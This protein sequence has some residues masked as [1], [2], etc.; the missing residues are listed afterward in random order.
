MPKKKPS[1]KL[2]TVLTEEHEAAQGAALLAEAMIS[3]RAPP[4]RTVTAHESL[5]LEEQKE[6]ELSLLDAAEEGNV[7][8]VT[9]LLADGVPIEA[10]DW[11][12]TAL[13]LACEKGH[14][15]LAQ[16]LLDR[17]ARVTATSSFGNSCLVYAARE[18][19]VKIVQSLLNHKAD[20]SKAK[21]NGESPI[22]LAAAGG[23]VAIVGRL[24]A[25]DADVNAASASGES[26][27]TRAAEEG[28]AHVVRA[29]L[30]HGAD[31]GAQTRSGETA[32]SLA[33][34]AGHGDVV[35]LLVGSSKPEDTLAEVTT[36]SMNGVE[37][38]ASIEAVP[39]AEGG[40]ITA[41]VRLLTATPPEAAGAATSA[42]NEQRQQQQAHRYFGGP[43]TLL[44]SVESG[45]IAPLS[46]RWVVALHERG[47][48]LAP[49]QQLPPEAFVAASTLRRWA[50]ALGDDFGVIFVVLSYK[51]LS[52]EH[53]D[54][55]GHH[56]AAVADVARTYTLPSYEEGLNRIS[57]SPLTAAFER[58]G[59]DEPP[60]F[61]LLWDFASLLQPPWKDAREEA[62]F[63]EGLEAATALWCGHAHSTCWMQSTVPEGFT[64]VPYDSSG[65]TFIEAAISAAVK[66]GAKRLDLGLRTESVSN[67]T[68]E[69]RAC[70]SG[71]YFKPANRL[72]TVCA[73]KRTV[74]LLPEAADKLLHTVKAF[75]VPADADVVSRVYRGFF[76]D[77]ATTVERLDF[78]TLSWGLSEAKSLA[79][80]LPRFLQ[81]SSLD[82]SHNDLGAEGGVA[83][84][85]A[86]T[87]CT[88]LRSLNLAE[89]NLGALGGAAIARAV[90]THPV[91]TSLDVSLNVNDECL[92]DGSPFGVAIAAALCQSTSL[93]S[94]N[95]SSN[96]LGD[97]ETTWLSVQAVESGATPIREGARVAHQGRQ[98]IVTDYVERS[99]ELKMRPASP[100]LA[101]CVAIAKA[102]VASPSLTAVDLAENQLGPEG[103]VAFAAVFVEA[104]STSEDREKKRHAT[105]LA[106][107]DLRE[108]YFE[109]EE[110]RVRS[111]VAAWY[112]AVA[113]EI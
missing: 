96:C 105:R 100:S 49:R 50:D 44:Q 87:A 85:P 77:V 57:R 6:R 2:A 41:V 19:H 113:V 89:C 36:V 60:D 81:L 45:A 109:D 88:R 97:G 102:L 25:S 43:E 5:P 67:L 11:R 18:G 17:S 46:G 71:G 29:L 13:V 51:W 10:P 31:S 3:F 20:A 86:L 103:A 63:G 104:A 7:A 28:H 74:P 4:Q 30:A 76:E 38:V 107:L 64:G 72:D 40:G 75:T 111:A 23:H 34:G 83:L 33:E 14:T 65:W 98:M 108:N 69:S 8:A 92:A 80:T 27:L 62:L 93:R 42:A 84:A 99:S 12:G 55:D 90:G 26:A 48:Q 9:A 112:S 106:S 54:P 78:P 39:V 35:D 59:L 52:A 22:M 21:K 101:G 15:E 47:S 32:L 91:L 95:L 16:L 70:Y 73:A 61:A 79:Q 37:V 1:P 58:A 94:V 53:P 66:P 24:A 56:L 82:V 68:A 110:G